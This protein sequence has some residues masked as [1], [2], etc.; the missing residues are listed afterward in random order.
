MTIPVIYLYYTVI[1]SALTVIVDES[2]LPIVTWNNKLLLLI[3]PLNDPSEY[4]GGEFKVWMG[5]D[6]IQTLNNKRFSVNVF[7]SFCMSK[8]TPIR[9]GTKHYLKVSAESNNYM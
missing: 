8:S 6:N 3:V 5:K 7:P 4:E 1:L 2:E 9:K